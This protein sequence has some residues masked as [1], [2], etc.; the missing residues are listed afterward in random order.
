MDAVKFCPFLAR[1]PDTSGASPEASLA[2]TLFMAQFDPDAHNA[3]AAELV[4]DMYGQEVGRD[5]AVSIL[6]ALKHPFL[7]VRTA[8]ASALAAALEEYPDTMQVC[9]S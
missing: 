1:Q 2:A 7:D 4:W 8:A 9:L 6:G 5:Y 3:E